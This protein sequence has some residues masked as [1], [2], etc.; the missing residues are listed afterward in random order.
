MNVPDILSLQSYMFRVGSRSFD[1]NIVKNF[2]NPHSNVPVFDL[3]NDCVFDSKTA[4]AVAH[5]QR[6]NRLTPTGAM[7]LATWGKMGARMSR[8]HIEIINR[9]NANLGALLAVEHIARKRRGRRAQHKSAKPTA[10]NNKATP[11]QGKQAGFTKFAFSVFV[12]AF[13]PFEWFGLFN[14]AKGDGTDR[15]FS[16]M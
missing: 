11:V 9:R 8:P 14:S 6:L 13:A 15:R 16:E 2:L 12:A 3:V 4:N 7:N 5:F 1:V 10:T